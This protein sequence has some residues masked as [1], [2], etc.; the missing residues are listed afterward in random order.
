MLRL[1]GIDGSTFPVANTPHVKK[2]MKKARIRR[3]RAAYPMVGGA[4]M[5]ELDSPNPLAAALGPHGE[6]EMVPAERVLSFQ[7]ENG[8]MISNRCKWCKDCGDFWGY[9][10]IC[11]GPDKIRILVRR[12]LCRIAEAANAPGRQRSC[13]RVLRKPVNRWPRL[14]KNIY[15]SGLIVRSAGESM[16]EFLNGNEPNGD[17]LLNRREDL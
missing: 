11:W 14:R 1:C 2:R 5:V 15:R 6:S 12:A 4:V 3:G 10:P 17:I 16:H 9:R 13:P 7:P 8:L